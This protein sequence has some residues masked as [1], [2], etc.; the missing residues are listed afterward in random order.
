MHL[1]LGDNV[2]HILDSRISGKVIE[3]TSKA[4]KKLS[5][6]GSF[7]ER[8]FALIEDVAGRRT[9]VEFQDI[10]KND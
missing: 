3:I 8:R 5:T 2:R 1:R 10:M 9:W 6:G 7:T 4:E